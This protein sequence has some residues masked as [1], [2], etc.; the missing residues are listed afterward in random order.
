[1]FQIIHY[2]TNR[3]YKMKNKTNLSVTSRTLWIGTMVMEIRTIMISAT[4][5]LILRCSRISIVSTVLV[6]SFF[7]LPGHQVDDREPVQI[8]FFKKKFAK[9]YFG[10]QCVSIVI[11]SLFTINKFIQF[12]SSSS[13]ILY[14]VGDKIHQQSPKTFLVSNKLKRINSFIKFQSTSIG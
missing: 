9:F 2:Q 3:L 13:S 6:L 5:N 11:L 14:R 4:F 1:M 7:D 12:D 8:L 10:F